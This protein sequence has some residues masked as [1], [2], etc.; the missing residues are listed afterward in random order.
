MKEYYDVMNT[1]K[2]FTADEATVIVGTVMDESMGDKLR[3]TM[4]ATGLNGA[5][6]KRE[7]KPELRV[8]T[9]VRNG[10]TDM[11]MFAEEQEADDEPAVFSS[12][13]RRAQVD[14]MKM[15]GVEEYD[16]PAF[17]RKQAD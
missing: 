1:I 16:I 4:V 5:I 17:L 11:P 2:E 13:N 12:N 10:T 14:A 8:M 6:A 9:T 7:Q 15:N 3:V